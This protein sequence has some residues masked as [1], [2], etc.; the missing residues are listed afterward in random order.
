MIGWGVYQSVAR[1]PD[2]GASV[3]H[4]PAKSTASWC[5]GE[6]ALAGCQTA[7]GTYVPEAGCQGLRIH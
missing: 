5:G 1:E 2:A 3:L 4:H 7:G 6:T